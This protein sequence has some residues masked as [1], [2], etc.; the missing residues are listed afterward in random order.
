M[1]T[2]R[3]LLID[4]HAFIYQAYYATLTSPFRARDGR[5]VSVPR[6]VLR[7]LIQALERGDYSHLGFAMEGGHSGRETI[8]PDYKAD[9]E[10]K[11]QALLEQIPMVERLMDSLGVGVLHVPGWEADDVLATAT[12]HFRGIGVDVV[13]A[14]FDKDFLQLVRPEVTVWMPARGRIPEKWITETNITDHFPVRAEQVVDFLALAGDPSDNIPGCPGIG[15]GTAPK[16]LERFGD[17]DSVLASVPELEPARAR[18]ALMAG[19]DAARMS[20]EL[21][22]MRT[23]VPLPFRVQDLRA[24]PPDSATLDRLLQGLALGQLEEAAYGMG[25]E[26]VSASGDQLELFG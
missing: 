9:R 26:I 1:S 24:T 23:D 18:R 22:R 10:E 17:L 21:V 25:R 6:G 7:F 11:P 20:R 8:H 3:A 2:R 15:K 19:A 5:D 14:T 16:L 4:G 13:I 12:E